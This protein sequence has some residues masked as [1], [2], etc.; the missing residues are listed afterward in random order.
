[1]PSPCSPRL[2][3]GL[4]L[5]LL[6]RRWRRAVDAHLLASG[7]SDSTWV[8]LYY[9]KEYGDGMTQKTLAKLICIDSSSLVRLLDILSRQGLIER[10]IDAHDG[11]A[12]LIHLTHHGETRIAEIRQQLARIETQLLMDIDDAD[13]AFMLKRF[14]QIEDRLEAGQA[15]PLNE[16]L[17]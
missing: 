14:D 11:R 17:E 1:M 8:P 16:R 4:R 12:R 2:I 15:P 9:L 6:A 13:L 10:R 7:L 5:S 3:F